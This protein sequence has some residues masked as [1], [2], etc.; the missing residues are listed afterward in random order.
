MK[1]FKIKFEYAFFWGITVGLGVKN[2]Q[3]KKK[4]NNANIDCVLFLGVL[5]LALNISYRYEKQNVNKGSF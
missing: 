2:Y 3:P 1:N 5:M 4:Y